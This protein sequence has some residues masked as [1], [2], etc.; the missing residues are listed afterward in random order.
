MHG[1]FSWV[2]LLHYACSLCVQLMSC[3]PLQG[4]MTGQAIADEGATPLHR[5]VAEATAVVAH[6]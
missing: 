3:G 4:T 2:S 1:L 5:A 6:L